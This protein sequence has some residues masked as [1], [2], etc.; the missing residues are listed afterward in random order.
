MGSIGD[1]TESSKASSSVVA[2]ATFGDKPEPNDNENLE[3]NSELES[4]EE[5]PFPFAF[6]GKVVSPAAGTKCRDA[7]GV[8]TSKQVRDAKQK[9]E[10]EKGDGEK[11]EK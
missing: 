5:P 1:T 3:N 7:K 2:T 11:K 8:R 6:R 4:D 9:E 10:L